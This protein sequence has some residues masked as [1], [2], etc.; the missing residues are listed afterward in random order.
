M[1]GLNKKSMEVHWKKRLVTK[2]E[3]F[4]SSTILINDKISGRTVHKVIGLLSAKDQE[5]IQEQQIF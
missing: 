2:L 1:E 5:N 3:K 4:S